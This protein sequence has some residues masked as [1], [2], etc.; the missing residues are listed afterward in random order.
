MVDWDRVSPIIRDTL[1]LLQKETVGFG[2][3]IMSETKYWVM[4]KSSAGR[5]FAALHPTKNNIRVFISCDSTKIEDP[6]KFT[7]ASA[8]TGGWGKKYPV[9]FN[10]RSPNDIAYATSLLKQAY[11]SVVEERR[12]AGRKEVMEGETVKP[13]TKI[14]D[15]VG[16]PVYFREFVYAPLN[17]A[18]VI[19]LFS[20]IMGELGIYYE[21]S[22]SSFPDMIA[23]RKIKEGLERIRVEFEYKSSHFLQH[24]HD[25]KNCDV[26]VCWEH[27]WKDCPLQVIELKEVIKRLR[28]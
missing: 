10:I 16:E 24:K 3:V 1:T 9:V 26:I 18:G 23:R 2:D 27:D 14:K 25:F 13:V 17:E 7:K 20:K 21:A 12:D 19:L 8:S 22:P 11:K 5:A 4:W 28:T 6:L 15:L